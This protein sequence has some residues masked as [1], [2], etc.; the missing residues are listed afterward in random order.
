MAA[1]FE[2][3]GFSFELRSLP[4]ADACRGAR[5]VSELVGSGLADANFAAALGSAIGRLPELVELFAPHCKVEG[6]GVAGGRK[7]ALKAFVGECFDGH[8]DRAVLF[9]A[10]CAAAEFGD[11]LGAGLERLGSGLAELTAKYP[12]LKAPTPTSGA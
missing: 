2:I 10:N 1:D 12:A 6:E 4:L 8:L 9:A 3:D 5:L 7:V 11:F